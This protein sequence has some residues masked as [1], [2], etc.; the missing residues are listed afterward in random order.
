MK[1]TLAT[2]FAVLAISSLFAAGSAQASTCSTSSMWASSVTPLAGGANVLSGNVDS[3]ACVGAYTGNDSPLP[4]THGSENLGYFGDGLVNGAAQS[5][6]GDT[7]GTALFPNG[8]FSSLYPVQDLNHDGKADPG[9]IY[10]GS[11]NGSSFTG[12]TIGN[13]VTVLN[14]TFSFN[15]GSDGKGTWAITPDLQNALAIAGLLQGNVLDQFAI[16]V[17]YGNGFQAFDFTASSLG[18]VLTNPPVLY[19]FSGGFD[20]APDLLARGGGF[21]HVDLYFRDPVLGTNVPEP[22]GLALLGLGLVGLVISRRRKT[23]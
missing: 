12:A 6:Q 10:A 11:S 1:K 16:V 13:A 15:V 22:A 19:N 23:A 5:G 20:L 18:L 7:G 3:T 21:S 17:K 2:S 4:G 14:S 9:W 8:M